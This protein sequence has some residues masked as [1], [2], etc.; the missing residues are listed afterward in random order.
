MYSIYQFGRMI[1]DEIRMDAYVNALQRA[2]TPGCSVVDLGTGTGIFAMLACHFGA[3][4]VYAIELDDAIHVA[5]ELIKDNGLL[6]KVK[7]VQADS[8]DFEPPIMADVMISDLRSVLPFFNTHIPTIIDARKRLLKPGGIQIP[9]KDDINVAVVEAH[10]IYH[11]YTMPWAK[12]TYGFDFGAARRLLVNNWVKARVTSDMLMSSPSTCCSLDYTTILDPNISF[13]TDIIIER[14]GTAHGLSVWFDATL[15]KG[16]TF[17]NSPDLPNLGYSMAFFPWET[18]VELLAGDK[19]E[20]KF[21]ARLINDNYY[22]SWD[23]LVLRGQKEIVHFKQSTF[24][25]SPSLL[26]SIASGTT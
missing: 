9:L 11:R 26:K 4:S 7:F 24:F 18:S 10:D 6:H 17:S 22:Y 8:R 19:V 2:I 13:S 12:N 23:S 20:L 21:D 25:S 5:R 14:D 15:A 1:G 3:G 16:I